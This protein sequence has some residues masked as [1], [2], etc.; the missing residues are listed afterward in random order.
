M[1]IRIS[2]KQIEIGE[3]LPQHVRSEL[4]AAVGK[5]FSGGGDAHVTFA[6]EG[7]LYRADCM[8]HLNSGMTLHAQGSGA[9]TYRAFDMAMERMQKRVRRYSRRLKNHHERAPDID[10]L[11]AMEQIFAAPTEEDDLHESD[12]LQ[13]VIV[14]E[15]PRTIHSWSVS[16]AVMQLDLQEEPVL[17]FRNSANARVNIVYRRG[18]GN[19]GWIDPDQAA[20]VETRSA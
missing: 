3:A 18:D 16:E 13:P 7:A 12:S 20:A 17:V 4:S 14:A 19:I 1:D 2:G 11:A 6:R 8:V 10:R 5:H 15:T 9:D